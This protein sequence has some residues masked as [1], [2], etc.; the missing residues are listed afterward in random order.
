[1]IELAMGRRITVSEDTRYDKEHDML[2]LSRKSGQRICIGTDVEL[3][4]LGTHGNQV[5]LG[6][7]APPEV[8]IHRVEV[9][10][11][12]EQEMIQR[13]DTTRA[14]RPSNGGAQPV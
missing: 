6:I 8:T 10:R 9:Q 4:V 7:A 13:R 14:G 3:V 1:V 2:V 12:I 11:R 5:R